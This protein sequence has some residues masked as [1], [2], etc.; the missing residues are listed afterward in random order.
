M[1]RLEVMYFRKNG[2]NR[3]ALKSMSKLLLKLLGQA[4]EAL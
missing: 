3:S 1:D 4:M 2:V